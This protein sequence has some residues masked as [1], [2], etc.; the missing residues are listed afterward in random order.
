M[1]E[2][3]PSVHPT[4]IRTSISPSVA[5][6]LNTTSALDNYA[7]EAVSPD[8][9][10]DMKRAQSLPED[11]P[12]PRISGLW[13]IHDRLKHIGGRIGSMSGSDG[14][15]FRRAGGGEGNTQESATAEILKMREEPVTFPPTYMVIK[16]SRHIHGKALVWLVDK[17]TGKRL[18][19]GA[20]LLVRKQPQGHDINS[21]L[22]NI[23]LSPQGLILHVSASSIKFLEVAEE[24]E[25]KKK[26]SQGLVREFTVSQLEDFLLD[27]MHVQDLIT[28]AD[29]QYIVRHEL[30]NIRALEEDIHVP[31]YPTLTLYEGQSIV[32]VCLH[33]ELLDSIYPLH[34]LEALEKLGNKW[35]WALFENQPFEEIRLYFGEAVALYFTFLGFY[36]TAL[37][38]PMVLGILQMLLS[39]ETLAF[40]CVFN[41]LWVTLFLE[42]GPP[43]AKSTHS[44]QGPLHHRPV[45]TVTNISSTGCEPAFAWRE[46]GKPFRNTSP[47]VHPTEIRTSIFPSSAVKLNTTSA[48][49]NY[50]TEAGASLMRSPSDRKDV[51]CHKV[52]LTRS[53]S[54]SKYVNYH[55]VLLT[56][57]PSDRKDVNCHKAWKR[58]CSELAFTWGTIGMTGLD[59][60]RP[61]YHGTM[62]I[63]TITGRYQPQFPK[64]KTY[65]RRL[66]K[67]RTVVLLGQI[68]PVTAMYTFPWQMYAVSFP[69]VF[70]CMLGAFFVMLLS[71]WTEEYL[72]ARRERGVRMGRLLV[73]LPS[74]VYTAL[75]YVMNTYYRRLATHL[76]EWGRFN[77]RI[78]RKIIDQL[79]TQILSQV[80]CVEQSPC[81]TENHRTQSQFDRHRVTKL[82]LFEFVNNFMS[83]FYIAFYIRDMDMLRSQLAVMLI[84]LQAINNF[85][86]AMLPLL[87]KQYGKRL[88]RLLELDSFFGLLSEDP[89]GGKG[90]KEHGY[91]EGGEP[92]NTTG[93]GVLPH[94]LPLSRDD[95]RIAQ[96]TEEGEMENYEGTYDDYLEMF[97]QF[98]YVFL[99]SSV[100]PIAA[101]WAVFNNILEV[102]ADA[103]KLCRVFQRP[104]ARRVKD[105]GA[106][107]RAFEALGALSI[108]TN[109]GLLCMSPQLRGLAPDLSNVEWV[110]L[111]VCL[112]HV[113]LAVRHVLHEAIPDVPGWVRLALAKIDY[114]S[115]QALKHEVIR[116]SEP[117]QCVARGERESRDT[118]RTCRERQTGNHALKRGLVISLQPPDTAVLQ[119]DEKSALR[120]ALALKAKTGQL[121]AGRDKRQ[122]QFLLAL[123][124]SYPELPDTARQVLIHRINIFY[125]VLTRCWQTAIVAEGRDQGPALHPPNFV[126][127]TSTKVIQLPALERR[128]WWVKQYTPKAWKSPSRALM[129]ARNNLFLIVSYRS[130]LL[131][132]TGPDLSSPHAYIVFTERETREEREGREAVKREFSRIQ[133][134]FL[135]LNIST[136]VAIPQFMKKIQKSLYGTVRFTVPATWRLTVVRK[137]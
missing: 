78:L 45:G 76:T 94:I 55:K 26:D 61:N 21:P 127:P 35:Y 16:F 77:F 134:I 39:S 69:I 41:V 115:K 108:V 85:Q 99:F 9:C 7:T 27:G 93:G 79:S 132:P 100:F 60:P 13:D 17:I 43:I 67:L 4:E 86:E 136:S 52:V 11:S 59:E 104:S 42:V 120:L 121:P 73:T 137:R 106:W 118:T 50:A 22:M 54:Y 64:W 57:S 62:A 110:L 135:K 117:Q 30:E 20:E 122:A 1:R 72:M 90:G 119:T 51:N 68:L 63:D 125:I 131:S 109:C 107:Q 75:V 92:G 111:V 34:D 23:F 28:T 2:K 74:I 38:V 5:V 14:D 44:A 10:V 97:I 95:P 133:Y 129:I 31:G 49:A 3:P 128:W 103:F 8:P 58:K 84:I 70:L 18:D 81:V 29:K 83:L 113:L 33:W 37:L 124:A 40:F 32:Q 19:G 89:T 65:L 101:F 36:T 25:I 15:S 105:T 56:R 6:E 87:I 123:A 66:G 130:P 102:R 116:S 71:F 82:V 46:S 96:A 112:E 80:R 98:G 114:Q 12:V 88:L 126:P 48:L 24:L 47:P 53:H 91:V